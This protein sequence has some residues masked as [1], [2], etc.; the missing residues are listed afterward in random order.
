MS[1]CLKYIKPYIC[2]NERPLHPTICNDISRCVYACLFKC[3]KST[4]IN[5]YITNLSSMYSKRNHTFLSTN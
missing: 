2:D 5:V 4:L 1:I 3:I